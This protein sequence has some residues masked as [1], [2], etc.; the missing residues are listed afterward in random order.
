MSEDRLEEIKRFLEEKV[1]QLKREL[2]VYELLL[3][4]M[5][6]KVVGGL[7]RSKPEPGEEVISIKSSTGDLLAY[8]YVGGSHVRLVPVVPI[9]LN[10]SLIQ[11]H[12]LRYLDETKRRM[13]EEAESEARSKDEV[14]EYEVIAD[15]KN[16]LRELIVRNIADELDMEDIKE[17]LRRG[18]RLYAKKY[19][20]KEE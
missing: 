17:T 20:R 15:D 18:I 13:A 16:N 1:T 4:L 6:S 12:L 2:E 5:E 10:T 9:N 11:L 8:L 7:F 14:I 19:L 3:G